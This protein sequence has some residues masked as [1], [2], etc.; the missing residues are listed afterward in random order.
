VV[1][2]LIVPALLAALVE[3]RAAPPESGQLDASPALFAVLAAI[4]AAGYDAENGSPSNHPVREQVR[5]EILKR[6][7]PSLAALK[8]FYAAHRQPNATAELGQYVS[9]ALSVGEPPEFRYKV[10]QLELPPD[11]IALEGFGPLLAKFYQEANLEDLWGRAQ[12]AYEQMIARYH[13]PVSKAVLEANAY[14]R[15]PTG[16][17]LGRRFQIYVDLLG[18]P[19]QVQTRSYDTEYFVVVTPSAEPRTEDLRHGYLHYLLDPLASKFHEELSKSQGLIDYAQAAP[20]L[21]AQ[22]KSDFPLLATESLVKAIES[23]LDMKRQAVDQAL[24]EGYILTPFFAAQLPAYEKQEQAMRLYYPE[25]LAALDLRKVAASLEKVEFAAA[26]AVRHAPKGPA[27]A[28][29]PAPTGA[30]KTLEDAEKL[31]TNRDLDRARAAFSRVL[32]ETD[33]KPAH[34]QAYYG[35]ARIA[36]LQKDPETGERF[37]ERAVESSPEPYVNGWA[38]VYLGRLADAAGDRERASEQYRGALAVEGASAAARKAA[39]AGLR[40]SFTK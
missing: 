35:L 27:P 4:N 32:Q 14:L 24:R 13:E 31:Y 11:A 30:R 7:P 37:L 15:S 39:E 18:A 19:N 25:M 29:P 34:A 26:A 17:F 33:D 3:G 16:N 10:R 40:E 38:H 21:P 5:Q 28:P 9:F 6:N 23:R 22:Y 20:A 36:I 1:I 8:Q 2:R 12:P